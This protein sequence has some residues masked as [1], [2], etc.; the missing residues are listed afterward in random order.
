MPG[1]VQPLQHAGPSIH[2]EPPPQHN[3]CKLLIVRTPCELAHWTCEL[4]CEQG[5][6]FYLGIALWPGGSVEDWLPAYDSST[7]L[8]GLNPCNTTGNFNSTGLSPSQ[9]L[10][11]AAC[12][13]P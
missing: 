4:L 9:V 5:R 7:G 12:S 6:G 10:V 13:L 1:Q 2:C 11:R 3:S 8:W